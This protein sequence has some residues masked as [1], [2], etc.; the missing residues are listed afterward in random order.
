MKQEFY[1]LTFSLFYEKDILTE[2]SEDR[3]KKEIAHYFTFISSHS[4]DQYKMK[5][6]I[7]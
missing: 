2:Q 5:T 7:L 6:K 4:L 1:S 3:K